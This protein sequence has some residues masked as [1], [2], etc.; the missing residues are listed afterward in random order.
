MFLVEHTAD[1]RTQLPHKLT[2]GQ[3]SLCVIFILCSG[4]Q[5]SASLLYY[6]LEVSYL[7]PCYLGSKENVIAEKWY[8]THFHLWVM[9]QRFKVY[10]E[11]KLECLV[12]CE[13]VWRG[14]EWGKEGEKKTRSERQRQWILL[15]ISTYEWKFRRMN[16]KH[17]F[18][19][20]LLGKKG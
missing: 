5:L 16:V 4:D 8:K 12:N 6:A 20:L 7:L 3:V 9:L 13:G 2:S 1:I 11:G 10:N 19:A 18:R 14:K 17:S 15:L